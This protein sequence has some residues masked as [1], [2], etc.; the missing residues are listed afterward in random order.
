MYPCM[1]RTVSVVQS[2]H[3]VCTITIDHKL[4]DSSTV[5]V[6]ELQHIQVNWLVQSR[7]SFSA[8]MRIG[9]SL[10]SFLDVS[11]KSI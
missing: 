4:H 11:N 6:R 3:V 8:Y 5:F 2:Y 9:L 10:C 1:L 7:L